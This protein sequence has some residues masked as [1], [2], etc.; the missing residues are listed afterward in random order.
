MD[1]FTFK[2]KILESSPLNYKSIPFVFFSDTA[3]KEQVQESYGLGSAGF[4][5]KGSSMKEIQETLVSIMKYWQKSKVPEYE[6]Q[7]KFLFTNR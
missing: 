5:I 4:F 7:S 6:Q 1:G 3:S 2:K